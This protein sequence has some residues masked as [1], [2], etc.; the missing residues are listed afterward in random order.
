MI[1]ISSG[2]YKGRVLRG[3][4]S[5]LIRPTMSKVKLTFFDI[6]QTDVKETIF[7]D[8]FAGSGNIGIEALSRG[9]KYAVF[10]D[11]LP[12]AARTIRHNAEKIGIASGSYRVICGDFNRSIIALAR[13]GFH[14]DLAYLDPPYALL[15]YA[16]PLKVMRKRGI[17]R[18]DG[19]VVLERSSRLRFATTHFTLRR[20][21]RVGRECLDF[22]VYDAG[23]PGEKEASE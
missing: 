5:P 7:L 22:F 17:M 3:G 13:D 18:P 14:F 19:L 12:E 16:D 8:G 6:L 21:Q 4:K 2:L 1:R 11:D 9:A 20:T 10:I 15:E 23:D